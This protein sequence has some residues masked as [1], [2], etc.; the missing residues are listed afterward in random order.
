MKKGRWLVIVAGWHSTAMYGHTKIETLASAQM[1]LP[2]VLAARLTFGHVGL[3]AYEDEC[4]RDPAI[5]NWLERIQLTVNDAL[6]QDGEP[7]VTLSTIDGRQ[8][9][10]CVE[11]ALGAPANPISDEALMRNFPA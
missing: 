3:D 2:Y 10:L 7:N 4:R 11:L 8:A 5:V 9:S 6:S 1:G